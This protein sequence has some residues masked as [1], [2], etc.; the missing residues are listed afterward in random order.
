MRHQSTSDLIRVLVSDDSRVHTELL[1]DALRRDGRLQVAT[2]ASGSEGLI[3]RLSNNNI[4]VL[5]L[6]SNLD[7]Q[8]GRGFEVLR[9]LGSLSCHPPA[10][11]LLDSS[12]HEMMLEA[13]RAGAR[14]VFCKQ[15]SAEILSK[16]VRKVHEGQIW[17]NSEQMAALVQAL[18]SSH[19]VRAVDVRGTNLLSKR[20]MEIVR[21]VAEGLTNRE[22]AGRLGL[23]PHTVK[24]CLF[25]VFDKLGAS[26]RVE[27]LFMTLSQNQQAESASQHLL[28]NQ[29]DKNFLDG[30]TLIACQQAAEEGVLIAQ[31]ALAEFYSAHGTGPNDAMRAYMWWSIAS[32]QM[33]RACAEVT[34]GMTV[35]Q[36]LKA[37][38]FAADWLEKLVRISPISEGKKSNNRLSA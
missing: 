37:E 27:L 4:D 7:E 10:V 15:E 5:L 26:S 28:K 20:E 19:Y 1:A 17:A 12:K 25:R 6:S 21:C 16:C 32:E 38:Q 29:L 13:F 22:I 30:P 34:K 24:N 3:G 11:M 36:L 31:L 2:A 14:G 23:S 9:G 18:A 8:P 35:D 33:S